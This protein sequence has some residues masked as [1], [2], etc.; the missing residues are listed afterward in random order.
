MSVATC[1][2]AGCE[3]DG[4]PVDVGDLTYTDEET[5]EE[6][7]MTVVCGPCGNPITDVS[8]APEPGP[9]VRPDQSLPETPDPKE[10]SE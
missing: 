4:I 2:T 6:Y 1:H 9:P 8:E 7:P 5:G 10:E 3:N